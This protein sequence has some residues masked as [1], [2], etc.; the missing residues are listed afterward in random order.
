MLDDFKGWI[1]A[2]TLALTSLGAG[3]T[4]VVVKRKK[5]NKQ[6]RKMDIDELLQTG[7]II[8]KLNDKYITELV[9]K[10][11]LTAQVTELD[12]INKRQQQ[13]INALDVECPEC[14]EC[15]EKMRNVYKDLFE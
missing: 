13:F 1:T 12:L 6:A 7:D 3:Y 11:E 4:W 10:G 9:A 15:L 14:A 5:L 2:I 8:S